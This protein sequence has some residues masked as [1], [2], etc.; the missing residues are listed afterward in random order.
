MAY[1][2]GDYAQSKAFG[3]KALAASLG[4][5]NAYCLARSLNKLGQAKRAEVLVRAAIEALK[6]ATPDEVVSVGSLN[7]VLGESLSTQ[8]RFADAETL[9]LAAY[10]TQKAHV[11]PQEYKFIET[12][13]RLAELYRAWGKTGEAKKYE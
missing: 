11:L 3:E 4:D 9:L 10:Q 6:K 12:R 2:H 1:R 5:E 8:H 7:S 13:Q